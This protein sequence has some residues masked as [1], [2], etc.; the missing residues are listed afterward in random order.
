MPLI[1]P[2]LYYHPLASYC[3][4][5]LIA[6]YENGTVFDKHLVDLAAPEQ[7]AELVALWPLGKF[8]VLRDGERV[9]AESSII[10]EYLDHRYPGPRPLLPRDHNAALEVRMWDRLVD[11]YVHAPM[12]ELVLARLQ[13]RSADVAR[14]HATLATAYGLADERLAS[15]RWLGGD[16]LTLADCAAA[17]ALFYAVTMLPFPAQCSRLSAYF[18]RLVERPS[19]RRTLDEAKPFFKDYPFAAAI[20]ARFR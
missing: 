10:V 9:V 18:E 1:P 19:V 17:P 4:K 16:E 12:Q 7:R 11:N 15:S 3:W 8:P 20:S 5:P 14:A 2:T 13:G 6:L